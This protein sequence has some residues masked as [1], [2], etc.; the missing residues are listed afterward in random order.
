MYVYFET[1]TF[2]TF[3]E[4]YCVAKKKPI[5]PEKAKL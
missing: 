5:R 2:E 4:Y 1:E 3:L